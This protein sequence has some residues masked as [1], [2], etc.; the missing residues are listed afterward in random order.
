MFDEPFNG[1]DPEVVAALSGRGVPFS[2]VAA[3]RASLEQA[4]LE[5]TQDAVEYRAEVAPETA[6]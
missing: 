4:Y 5:L 1:M 3:H 2:E 6:R